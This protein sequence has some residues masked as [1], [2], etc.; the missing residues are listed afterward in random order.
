MFATVR[1]EIGLPLQFERLAKSATLVAELD[2]EG[3]DG[4]GTSSSR[5]ELCLEKTPSFVCGKE[6]PPPPKAREVGP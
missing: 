3:K 1:I 2:D 5:V 4:F 6:K